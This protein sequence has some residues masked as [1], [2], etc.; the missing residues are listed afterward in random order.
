MTTRTQAIYENGMLR[1]TQS[2]ELP[3]GTAVEVTIETNGASN[4]NSVN[5]A[6][7]EAAIQ[8]KKTPAEIMAEIAALSVDYGEEETSSRDHDQVLYGGRGAA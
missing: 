6:T 8:P 4:A 3:E 2:L 7:T 1:L 5:G